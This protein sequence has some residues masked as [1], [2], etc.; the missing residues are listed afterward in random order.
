M[1]SGGGC[2]GF[3]LRGRLLQFNFVLR[4]LFLS[5]RPVLD[6]LDLLALRAW[7]QDLTHL[8]VRIAQG[9]AKERKEHRLLF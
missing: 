3:R 7:P 6:F 2:G 1:V 5:K 9:L 8:E 4:G